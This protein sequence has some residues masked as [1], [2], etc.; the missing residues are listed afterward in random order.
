MKIFV[1]NLFRMPPFSNP[2]KHQKIVRMHWEQMCYQNLVVNYSFKKFHHRCLTWSE[3]HFQIPLKAA[4]NNIKNLR[5]LMNLK[6]TINRYT[7]L[8]I[9]LD[10]VWAYNNYFF[11]TFWFSLKKVLFY[12]VFWKIIKKL[13]SKY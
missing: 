7:I 1:N 11:A 9:F 10:S 12:I 4:K 6:K 13:L 2:W 8:S 3:I 5:A